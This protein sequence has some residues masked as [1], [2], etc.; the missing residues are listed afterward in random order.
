[1]RIVEALHAEFPAITYDATIK[2]EHL[3]KHRDLLGPL[4]ETGC[5]FV[6]SAVESR[7]RS[8][9]SRKLEKNHTR[10]DFF[11]AVASD[12]RRGPDASADLHRVHALDHARRLSRP[13]ADA[14]GVGSG[15]ECRFGATG[16]AA[17]DHV[18]RRGC[19]SL[20]GS[21]DVGRLRSEGAGLSVEASPTRKWTRWRARVSG[22]CSEL[23]KQGNGREPRF[24]ARSARSGRNARS[25]I[26]I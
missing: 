7:G 8:R 17:A 2:I 18:R 1:M 26:S 21:A 19:W 20:D 15:G 11:E 16:A 25:K 9:C 24:F 23:Q 14:G 5:L 10:R 13:A 12:A 22:R 3:L 4:R 6:T